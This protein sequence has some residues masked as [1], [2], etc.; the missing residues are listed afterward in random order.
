MIFEN[1]VHEDAELSSEHKFSYL[2]SGLKKGSFAFKLAAAYVGITG[3]YELAWADL[4]NHYENRSDLKTIH[5]QALKD[6]RKTCQVKDARNFRQLETLRQEVGSRVNA[7]KALKATPDS[8]ES[9]AILGMKEALP[10]DLRT[11]LFLE[12][13]TEKTD[14]ITLED[15]L[16]FLEK[17]SRARRRSW[18]VCP[19]S[20]RAPYR[21]KERSSSN[22]TKSVVNEN[23]KRYN[24]PRKNEADRGKR[25]TLMVQEE[26]TE[27]EVAENPLSEDEGSASEENTSSEDLN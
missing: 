14:Q 12:Q 17:E 4:L 26:P 22:R 9:L 10:E 23:K 2:M 5:M 16:R 20:S 7:L 21:E 19:K 27:E 8:Y 3:A 18:E 25:H 15:L 13:D 11:K 1:E 24:G 6:L